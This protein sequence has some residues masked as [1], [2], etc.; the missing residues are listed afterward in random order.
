[1]ISHKSPSSDINS[2]LPSYSFSAPLLRQLVAIILIAALH[3]STIAFT[4]QRLPHA[5]TTLVWQQRAPFSL[6]VNNG[7]MSA[8][9]DSAG[10]L[11]TPMRKRE[12][13]AAFTAQRTTPCQLYPIALSAKSVA[14]VAAGAVVNDIISGAQPGNFGW[15][16]W[17]GSPSEPTLVTSLT[18]PGNSNTYINP[19]NPS[20]RELSVGDW[21][22]GKPGVTNSKS[23]RDALDNLKTIDL[24]VPVWNETQ[25]Q[26]NN[27]LYRVSAFAKVRLL[28]Y[29]LTGQSRISV[30]FLGYAQCPVPVNQPPVANA[31]PD[32]TITLPATATLNGI[33]TDDGLP[34]G[35]TL[36]VNWSALSG[37][38][39]VSFGD[40]RRA[41]TTA[42]F[43]QAG[44]YVLR[45]SASDS[46]FTATD[47]VTVTVKAANQPPVVNAGPDQT[48]TLPNGAQ[49]NGMATDDG[50]PAGSTLNVTWSAVSG[51]G[52]VTFANPAATVT[53]ASFS[54]AGVYV[55]RLTASD[56]Q[57]TA[58]DEVTVTVNAPVNQPPVVDAGPDQTITLPDAAALAGTATDDGL[59]AG[60]VLTVNWI[61]VSGPGTVTFTNPN[62]A[63]T[64]ASF[65]EPGSYVLRLT[66]SDT[67]L[68]RSDEVAV[69]VNQRIGSRIYTLNA[70][71]DEGSLINVVHGAPD[72]LQLDDTV[73]AFNFI[74]V[75]VSTKGTIV[76]I[77]TETGVVLGEYRTAPEGQPQDP[78]RTTVD[79]NGNVWATNRAGNS[80][81]HVGLLENG[82]CVDRNGN[83][84]IDTSSGPNDIFAWSN[85]GS[86]DTD[87][88][89]STAN[90]ECI[91]H[92]T[93]VNS[94]GTRHVSVNTD[95]DIWVSGTGGQRFD[96][97]DGRTGL[98]K[99]SELSVGYGGY[100]GLIDKNGVIWSARPL[101]RWDTAK[102]LTGPNGVNWIGYSHDSYGLCIDSQGNVWNT[103][104]G[105]LTRKFAPDGTL[106]GIFPHG[107]GVAQGCVVGRNDDVWVAHSILGGASTVGHLKNDG[108]Y[109]G[110]V[111]VGSGPTGVAVDGAGKI[112]A[113]NY[114]SRTVS[115]IDPNAG[116]IGA[117]GITPVGLVDFTTVDLGGNL[118]NYSDM[119]G[120]TLSGAPAEGTWAVVFDSQLPGAEWGRIG[121]TAGVCGEGAIVVTIASSEDGVTFGPPETVINGAD[122]SV[123]NGRY[124]KIN[125]QFQRATSGE[126]PILY[127]LTVGTQGF[128]LPA[129]VNA[130]PEVNAGPDQ[131]V[132]ISK[133]ATLN[134]TACDDSLPGGSSLSIAWSKVSGPGSVTFS[135]PDQV[136]T[137][138]TFTEPGTY[139]L[140][141]TANDSEHSS[142]DQ[143]TIT[144]TAANQAPVVNAGQDQSISLPAAA[145]LNGT[146]SDDGLPVGSTLT[147]TWSKVSGPGDVSFANPS[148][149]VTTASFSEAGVYVLRL[150][151]N[152]TEL[153]NMDD[154][155]IT[156]TPANHA[157]SVNAGPDQTITL[158][159][160]ASLSG[161]VSDDGLP[162]GSTLTISWSKASGPGA[163]T[164]GSPSQAATTATFSASG[165]YVLR[166]TASDSEHSS[167]DEVTITVTAANL[168]PTVNAGPDQSITLPNIA[169]LNGT[170]SDDGLP[171]G[172]TLTTTWSKVSGPG[173]VSFAN[174]GVTVT[175]ASFST[176]GMYV[177]RLR[178]SD[179]ELSTEDEV[180]ITVNPAT[181]PPVVTINSPADG[182]SITTRT[183]FIGSVSNGSWRLEYSL[184]IDDG[185]AS[186]AWTTI[187]SGSVPV[188]N[189]LLGTFDPTLLL[190][191]TYAVRL[192]AT[193]AGGQVSATSVSAVVSGGEKVGNFTINFNDLLMPVVGLPIDVVRTYDS[194]DKRMG[195]FG[196]GWTLGLK[197]V[198]VEKTGVLGNNWEETREGGFFPNYCLRST[199]SH[200]VTITFPDGKVYK[201]EGATQ[202]QC[203]LLFPVQFATFAF[204]QVPGSSG[205]QGASLIPLGNRDVFVS[206]SIP[207]PVAL[208]D[209]DD[210]EPYN[211]TLFQ[212]TT[213]EGA[214]YVID[215][216]T[217]VRSM[218]DANGNQLTI[219]GNGIIHSSGKS[220][221][222]TRDAQG[223]I[224]QITDPAGNVMSYGYNAGGDLV[225][226]TDRENNVTTFSYNNSHGLTG[227]QDPRGIQPARNEYDDSGRLVRHIDAFGK[228]INY[229]Y[230]LNSRQELITDR[231]GN[232]TLFEY[233][234]RG[235]VL[236]ITDALGGVTT[237]T[238]DARDN[239]LSETNALGKTTTYTYDAQDNKLS[240]TDPLGNTT[241]YT[242][243]S[244]NQ[245]LTRTDPRGGVT[246]Y[247]Y[248]AN[249]NLLSARDA[250]GN[251][252]TFIYNSKGLETSNT[253]AL[254]NTTSYEYNARDELVKET[255]PLGNVTTYSYDN[256]GNRLSKTTT[257]TTSTGAVETLTT[258]YQY[259]RLNRLV[260]TTHPDGS[261][262]ETAYNSIGKPSL[263][264]DKM[265]RQTSFEYDEMSRLTRTIF[266]DSRKEEA[267]YDAEGRRT[268]S[269]DN[270]GRTTSYDYDTL[271]RLIK[272][273]FPDGATIKA[274]YDAIGRVTTKTDERGNIT[275]YDYDPNCG[276]SSRRVKT[277]DALGRVTSFT[278]DEDGNRATQTDAKG[279]TTSYE[280]DARNRRTRVIYPDNT[281]EVTAYDALD[282]V[283]AK[284]DQAGRTTQFEY[285]K[286]GR[287]SKIIDA[288]GK[289]TL[290]AY[291][292][293][294][295]RIS[296]TDANGHTTSYEY[297]SVGLETRRKLPLGMSET[298]A[299]DAAGNLIS[300]INYNGQ[301]MTY[302]YDVMNRMVS[303]AP[304]QGLGQSQIS[305]TYTATGR[306]ATMVDGTGTT[307]YTYDSRER[308]ISKA[309]PQGTL[310]YAYDGSGNLL[311]IAS[312]NAGGVSV[313][314]TYDALNRLSTVTDNRL[315]SATNSYAYDAV[316]NMESSTY[317]N[318]T[319]SVY[320]YNSLNRLTNLSVANATGD[321]AAYTYT[322]APAG[323]RLS[324][325]ELNGRQVSYTYDALYRLTGESIS[326]DPA[327]NNGTV[328][329]T[330]DA[331]GN[332]LSRNSTLAAIPS[333]TQNYD[334]NDRLT[335][336]S[337]DNNG[338]T[339]AS[340]G[341]AYGYDM[342]NR[343]TSLNGGAATFVYDGDGNRVAKTVGGVTTKYLVDDR[344]LTGQRQVMEEIVSGTVQRVYTYGLDLISQSQL[345]G[346]TWS[347]SF[348]GY[349]G[350]GNV[351]FLTDAGGAITDT[352]DYDAFGNLTAATGSTP[353][354]YLYAGEHYDA[355]IGFYYLRARYYDQNAGRFA[356]IDPYEGSIFDPVSLHKYLYAA[357]DPVNKSD[358]SG[359]ST[360]IDVS[361]AFNI[362][363]VVLALCLAVVA[364]CV[365]RILLSAT[366]A[367]AGV[368]TTSVAGPCVAR[369]SPCPPCPSPPPPQIHYDHTHFPCPGAHWHNFVYNQN[370]V[371]C[372][373]YLRR[374][375]GGCCG[376]LG[377]PC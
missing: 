259:D 47:E 4:G 156:V 50:L 300:R 311:S 152:D 289:A 135:K 368:D 32:Q 318:G 193:D 308:L 67:E 206:G 75:A 178:A 181:P 225:S 323:N 141:L 361:I 137:E 172:S 144:V 143:V 42:S 111:S 86:A 43:S 346:G 109:I 7:G 208:L 341:N 287:L 136:K 200:L 8:A 185:S 2:S 363:T 93:R 270:A 314:Y 249:G 349:D 366:L 258:S 338:N 63:S 177:L 68:S 125:V 104:L 5:P 320:S 226:F 247:T 162:T 96:L 192:V 70:D 64:Q 110:N 234:S 250:L 148:A 370:P 188:S 81:V 168:P 18:P 195:D 269:I 284:T 218:T 49:L 237:S 372:K 45:L 169:Q 355:N 294:D 202:P 222:F 128:T 345:M 34:T 176:A 224:T 174:P 151:A 31:G 251:T 94:S 9:G 303:K 210:F 40:P 163:V 134:G 317:A 173:D 157:P 264:T 27:G 267:T 187:A 3:A 282:H 77:N 105:S 116:P 60:S 313:S 184:N 272:T 316:G 132:S 186:Q 352:Y 54:K 209:L 133:P 371:N 231:L 271:G 232:A 97:I 337:Y 339:T 216:K 106:L 52:T 79:H 278:Y 253:D 230:D 115:R 194:R 347:T 119:T 36:A 238:Y 92:Y 17:A 236:R 367:I 91:L 315:A 248:D 149:M 239:K 66:A 295:N 296:Q 131:T 201:F 263:M 348:Y 56:S 329:Y 37:P 297:N 273:T 73:K 262:T 365:F 142:N 65:S 24:I 219:N 57:L 22:Q 336:S 87:G 138:A 223:R 88:G 288:L 175:T 108:T 351:R 90:D 53:T 80:V 61:K 165:T 23:V 321:L 324:V 252:T 98:I 299:Y 215:Q 20:D 102:P 277:T 35:S 78:S 274:T 117:D 89:V 360:L 164:F 59:P 11:L 159:S 266:P 100:G 228:V 182:S 76:K 353:N 358:P 160:A 292:E 302:A 39:T 257:R 357:N 261:V 150:T 291:D 147:T 124:L 205:T 374:T 107:F 29:Q 166:L 15:L 140:R 118:Y 227:I 127:D 375:F 376:D 190:N 326:G 13:T 33:V 213:A 44:V 362:T 281:V 332:R 30:R 203:Q 279:N 290:Y 74:W 325:A 331:V 344:N 268:K 114:Y 244:R 85:A 350:H 246:T 72:Q 12:G 235:N 359:L 21:M 191:G 342:E 51:P 285:D 265:G 319:N 69:T 354:T 153:S 58:A 301:R 19:K 161:T 55:L 14:G 179:A 82:Q 146:V 145:N 280:Y 255:N 286:L 154:L 204:T 254:G 122:P 197:N 330:Y 307:T 322:L 101:L 364:A 242:Y 356:T 306:R 38:G 221:T 129:S 260:K 275:T 335:N 245:M 220:I 16:T 305:Y 312:S 377:A 99:R 233:D 256:N 126:S 340:G 229:A 84:V 304:E 214:V 139:V 211:S 130:P 183:N 276:C 103:E 171:V 1:M 198:R 121:W 180:S 310:S 167:S 189:G 333:T 217:G 113:T 170:V 26:G 373:C 293:V 10:A 41:S 199:K 112:W 71:F 6:P 309:T 155:S 48:I 298:Y 328:T 62:A 25:G 123:A 343:L 283:T 28:S 334:A 95:N 327:A 369:R 241:R 196:V 158:P 46:Q 240:E 243:N 207:G 212:L 83:G 120:S